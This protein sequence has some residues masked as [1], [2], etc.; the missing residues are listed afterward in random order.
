MCEQ[1][2]ALD[3]DKSLQQ[4]LRRASKRVKAD[5][6]LSETDRNKVEK[7]RVINT[8]LILVQTRSAQ[9]KEYLKDPRVHRAYQLLENDDYG[10]VFLELFKHANVSHLTQMLDSS[11]C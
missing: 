3:K 11:L 7:R 2:C 1:C 5:M 6:Q 9:L 8:S 10:R 4:Q